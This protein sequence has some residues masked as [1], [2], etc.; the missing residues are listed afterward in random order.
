ME[1]T[2]EVME[3]M[4][5]YILD[6]LTENEACI[7]CGVSSA[8][9]RRLKDRNESVR[10]YFEQKAV[11][12]KHKHLEEIQKTKS[13]KNSQWLLEKLRPD[14]FGSKAKNSNPTTV[15]VI[16]TIINS[17]QNGEQQSNLLP[18][19]RNFGDATIIEAESRDEVTVG[20][21]LK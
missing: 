6:G 9:L 13:E 7:L 18:T 20:Q 14:E 3:R 16:K 5:K 4:A 17:I 15:N 21:V 2:K 8:E 12:F 1:I 11:L 10:L 19:A